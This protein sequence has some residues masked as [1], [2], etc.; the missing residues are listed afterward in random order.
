MNGSLHWSQTL[1]LLKQVFL[2]KSLH[3]NARKHQQTINAQV[4]I[5]NKNSHQDN[6]GTVHIYLQKQAELKSILNQAIFLNLGIKVGKIINL[7]CDLHNL[8]ISN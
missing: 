2:L 6:V 8:P 4:G 7:S 1:K 5:L 3:N